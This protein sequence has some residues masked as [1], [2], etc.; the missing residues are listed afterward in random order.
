MKFPRT[1]LLAAA[2]AMAA[3]APALADEWTYHGGPKGPP[4][5]T[6]PDYGNA[7]AYYGGDYAYGGPDYGYGYGGPGYYGGYGGA[8]GYFGRYGY[9]VRVNE[10]LYRC[11]GPAT[12]DCYNSRA[13]EGSR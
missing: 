7:Y 13:L 11:T 2:L 8:P 10:P 4:S 1:T 5:L 9:G 6:S 3:A 12:S